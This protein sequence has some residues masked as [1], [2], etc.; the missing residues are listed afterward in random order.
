MIPA[1]KKCLTSYY[2]Q[3]CVG[4]RDYLPVNM[5]GATS[6][7]RWFQNLKGVE[8]S[9]DSKA[10]SCT[11][12]SSG[13]QFAKT[14][15]AYH[16]LVETSGHTLTSESEYRHW[17]FCFK[18]QTLNTRE[19]GVWVLDVAIDT[20]SVLI[21]DAG[22]VAVMTQVVGFSCGSSLAQSWLQKQQSWRRGQLSG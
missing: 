3:T 5:K 15:Y 20:S 18:I 1:N 9:T 2:L 21:E 10:G 11:E 19:F 12:M 17:K 7:K 14:D 16:A 13:S 6:L 4:V 8:I 22:K